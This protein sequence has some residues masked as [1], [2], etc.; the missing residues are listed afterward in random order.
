[1]G[2]RYGLLLAAAGAL[3]ADDILHLGT[4]LLDRP[5]LITLGVQ[6]PVTGDDNFNAAVAMRYR[7]AGTV[8]WHDALPLLRV[9]AEVVAGWKVNPQF[10]GSIFDLLPAT[11]YEIELHA[12][13]PDGL[14]QII[15]MTGTTRAIPAGPFS[16]R[17]RQVNT[18]EEFRTALATAQ[19]GDIISLAEGIYSGQFQVRTA[20][21]AENPIVIRGAGE[22]T[23]LDAGCTDCNVLEIYGA[24]FVHVERLTISGA[25]GAIRFQTAGA[26][27]NVVR[28]VHTRDTRLG[29]N[30]RP[31]QKDF[32]ICDNILEGRLSWPL[33]YQDDGG[34]HANDDGIRVMGFG[35][36]VCHNRIGGFGDAIKT[37][38]DGARAIDFYGNDI[39]YT[40]DNGM[41]LDGS[42]GNTRCFRNRF[43]NTFATLSVQPVYGGPAYLFRNVV[44]NVVN[45]QMKFHAL[46]TVPPREPTGILAYHN[47]F[48]SAGTALNL[49][50]TASSH[51]FVVANN[52]FVGAEHPPFNRVVDWTGRIDNGWFDYNGYF[53]DGVFRF[54]LPAQGGLRTFPD[55]AALQQAG[56]ETHGARIGGDV[57]AGGLMALAQWSVLVEAPDA[58]LAPGSAAADAGLVLPNINDA[59][60]GAA[61]DLGALETACPM[62][63][64]GPRPEAI[65]ETNEP[66]DCRRP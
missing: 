43:A 66:L 27:G 62:P 2:L 9:H 1:M 55:L 40:Y 41:E 45:E 44:V 20:G 39:L 60:T 3:L 30:A 61:P 53:P 16:P 32:Y 15:S 28:R 49:Q 18:A 54:N 13:D 65:D 47:T 23:V 22:G 19:P 10:A 64:Y 25:L 51:H 5:T 21:T 14:D 48:V 57:F 24:G 36:V 38:Q 35:H 26:E 4:P 29:I 46:G 34:V 7:E 31:D 17:V 12:V 37:E 52:L 58:S 33:T 6:L 50:T 59:F 8:E 63:I 56:I 42:E 11:A